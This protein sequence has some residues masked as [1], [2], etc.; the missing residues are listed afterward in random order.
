[1][2][3]IGETTATKNIE[4]ITPMRVGTAKWMLFMLSRTPKALYT[5][6]GITIAAVVGL[7]AGM[8]LDMRWAIVGIMIL[9]LVLPL[10]AAMLFFIYGLK[11]VNCLN[12]TYHHIRKGPD[13]LVIK[14]MMPES[15]VSNTEEEKTGGKD[16]NVKTGNGNDKERYWTIKRTVLIDSSRIAESIADKGGEWLKVTDGDDEQWLFVPYYSEYETHKR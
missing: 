1:M 15:P 7:A 4:P 6:S 3:P 9:L 8:V 16:N 10:I 13:G 5:V 12:L 11:E 2:R 14:I